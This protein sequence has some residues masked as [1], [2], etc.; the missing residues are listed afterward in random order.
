MVSTQIHD[1]LESLTLAGVDTKRDDVLP[2]HDAAESGEVG[3]RAEHAAVAHALIFR[4]VVAVHALRV[5]GR[6]LLVELRRGWAVLPTGAA[7]HLVLAGVG[8]LKERQAELPV[9][10]V[11]LLH[12]LR[13][14]RD[15]TV[16]RVDDE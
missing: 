16:G 14:R 3:L 2:L 4:A 8:V 13:Q 7:V 9:E 5:V 12:F 10:T 15:A 1:A 6:R 11:P